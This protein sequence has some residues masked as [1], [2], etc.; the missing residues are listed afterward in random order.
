MSCFKNFKKWVVKSRGITKISLIF[1]GISFLPVLYV[2]VKKFFK[3]YIVLGLKETIDFD[4]LSYYGSLIGSYLII[5]TLYLENKKYREEKRDSVRPIWNIGIKYDSMISKT[6]E[7]EKNSKNLKLYLEPNGEEVYTINPNNSKALKLYRASQ[8]EVVYIV[9]QYNHIKIYRKNEG[10]NIQR[11]EYEQ[12]K[13][14]SILI[15]IRNIGSG[16]ALIDKI[17]YKDAKKLEGEHVLEPYERF[18]I[19]K[20]TSNN[21]LLQFDSKIS[22]IRNIQVFFI[23]TLGNE[24]VYTLVLECERKQDPEYYVKLEEERVDLVNLSKA[25][26]EN[27]FPK[28]LGKAK[29]SN[30]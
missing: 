8:N 14:Q 9:N 3:E 12:R 7:V 13:T 26:F 28:F 23:D 1:V 17:K 10:K 22:D 15:K 24:Y 27:Y 21:L 18:M 2:L 30:Q 5:Y 20:G 11:N 4:W 25:Y 6:K 19:D 29:E 16:H